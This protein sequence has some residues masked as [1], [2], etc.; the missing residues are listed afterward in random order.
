MNGVPFSTWQLSVHGTTLE[1]CWEKAGADLP[2]QVAAKCRFVLQN[3]RDCC[4]KFPDQ[5]KMHNRW[6]RRVKIS[7]VLLGEIYIL[8]FNWMVVSVPVSTCGSVI[9]AFSPTT[10]QTTTFNSQ[11]ASS[12]PRVSWHDFLSPLLFQQMRFFLPYFIILN[13]N[14]EAQLR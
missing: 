1:R 11:L 9:N 5:A 6:Q 7:Y 13:V 8:S 10:T 3:Q 12:Q 2:D 14:G 4:E